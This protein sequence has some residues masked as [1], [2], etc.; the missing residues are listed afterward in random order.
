MSEQSKPHVV[1]LRWILSAACG[2]ALLHGTPA[3]AGEK[4]GIATIEV[5]LTANKKFLVYGEETT[6]SKL[7]S[8]LKSAGATQNTAVRVAIGN[9][10]PAATLK[11]IAGK[12]SSEGYRRVMFA[13]PRHAEASIA[14]N[15]PA[16]PLL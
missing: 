9:G 13:L 3:R 8:K 7:P 15:A 14:S 2:L 10:T 12:L 4:S 5:T 6:L 16:L 11:A 1:V